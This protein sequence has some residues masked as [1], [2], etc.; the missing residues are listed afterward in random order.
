MS[1]LISCYVISQFTCKLVFYSLLYSFFLVTIATV[2]SSYII[3]L[4]SYVYLTILDF[5]HSVERAFFLFFFSSYLCFSGYVFLLAC[6][7]FLFNSDFNRLPGSASLYGY[8][9][10]LQA[11]TLP[12]VFILVTW[13]C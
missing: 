10:L 1:V 4:Y 6:I 9:R 5:L 12:L 11:S 7:L 13:M 8:S 3:N 2:C